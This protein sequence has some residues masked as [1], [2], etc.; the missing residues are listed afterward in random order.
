MAATRAL[1]EG[2][3]SMESGLLIDKIEDAE[4][5]QCLQVPLGGE[6]VQIFPQADKFLSHVQIMP[7][8]EL[9]AGK[10]P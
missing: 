10:S 6:E 4:P 7:S 9:T 5:E 3:E 2:V 1:Y 8:Y